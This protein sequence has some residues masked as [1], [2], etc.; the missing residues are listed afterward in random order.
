MFAGREKGG[1]PVV[2]NVKHRRTIIS[3]S[4]FIVQIFPFCCVSKKGRD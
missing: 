3:G 4:T 1:D 2:D